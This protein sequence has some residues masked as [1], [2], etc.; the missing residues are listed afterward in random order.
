MFVP[1]TN[2]FASFKIFWFVC[3]YILVS[4]TG[5]LLSKIRELIMVSGCAIGA[6][7]Q[8]RPERGLSCSVLVQPHFEYNFGHHN[9]RGMKKLL[10][11]IQ[12][13]AMKMKDLE[14]SF[15]GFCIT[16]TLLFRS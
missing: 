12:R 3:L 4:T 14:I 5:L 2:I 15:S 13:D 9:V 16:E 7:L 1:D 8:A 6:A 11:S 10:Q